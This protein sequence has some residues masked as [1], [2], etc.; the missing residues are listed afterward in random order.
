MEDN[1]K[2]KIDKIYRLFLKRKT[3]CSVIILIFLALIFFSI[4]TSL[5]SPLF[6]NDYSTVVLDSDGNIMRVYL[7]K[8]SQW[9][10]PPGEKSIPPKLEKS[11]ITFEDKRF[12][13]HFG[14]DILAIG[15]AAK[16]NLYRKKRV[17]GASTITMQVARLMR[18][19]ERGFLNKGIEIIQAVKIE[20]FYKKNEILKLYL[21]HAP[22]GNNIIGYRTASLK[23]FGIEPENLTWSQAAVLAVIPKNPNLVRSK[24]GKEEIFKKKNMVLKK[25]YNNNIIDKES[26]LLASIEE[27]KITSN[28]FPICAPHLSDRIKKEHFG[29]SVKTTI[30]REIQNS[31]NELVKQ[32]MFGFNKLGIS[33]CAA[34]VAETATGKVR[35]Y[36]GSN[37]Y[38][39]Y[40]NS[41][42]VD[43][44]MAFNSTGS[45]LK[46][47]LY[48][49]MIDE[50]KLVPQTKIEDIPRSY[51]GYSPYNMNMKF[52]GMVTAKDALISSLNSPAVM[53]LKDY[54]YE[55]FY[56]F[57][58]ESGMSSLF[59][60]P[61]GYGLSLIL[62]GAEGSLYDI[63]GMY[64]SLGNYGKFG[65]LSYLESSDKNQDKK[66]LISQGA[67]WMIL[68]SLR[69]LRRPGTEYYWKSFS[70]QWQIAWKTGTSYGNRDAWAVGV[71]PQWTIG[72]WLGNFNEKECKALSGI[73]AAAPLF[74]SIF[75]SLPK[76]KYSSWFKRPESQMTPIEI[77]KESGYRASDYC[78]AKESIFYPINAKPLKFSP[79]EKVIFTNKAGTEEV[80][81]LCWKN[82]DIVKKSMEIYPPQVTAFLRTKGNI[83]NTMLP[84]KKECPSN[85]KDEIVQIVYPQEKSIILIPRNLDNQYE[86][87]KLK[88]GSSYNNSTLYWYIDSHY[89]GKSIGR[90]EMDI[91]CEN[92]WHK[93]YVCDENGN[94]SQVRFYS[95]K[96]G[97]I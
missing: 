18:P 26:Y 20:F 51:N 84:H 46:P 50:G 74:F 27:V 86:K 28:S 93:L 43:G 40:K 7:N 14:V 77:S 48:A 73:E 19:K 94:S 59:R 31:V 42:Q 9:I 52:S 85:I 6:K 11:V 76:E 58:K 34:I 88:A 25:L 83:S 60:E 36:V 17:S 54:G 89:I 44:V 96:K 2:E 70:N 24:S 41:G 78:T 63:A 55:N 32:H 81:S 45:I 64:A 69:E 92:G 66:R 49:L 80:C 15:R 75:A 12:Y 90:H 87:I 22:Y 79:Y 47:F 38:F 53:L 82:G 97:K 62:G 8:K 16:T 61:D 29:K 30:N 67:S 23:Y 95:E 35:A 68:E 91:E 56:T 4:V 13:S 21:E 71:S 33:N 5:P 65:K 3:F 37:N 72:I 39:D 10:I 57:L 1:L